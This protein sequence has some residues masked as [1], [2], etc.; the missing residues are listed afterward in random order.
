MKGAISSPMGVVVLNKSIVNMNYDVEV[1]LN[2][3]YQY[4][5]IRFKNTGM[6]QLILER[7]RYF[8]KTCLDTPDHKPK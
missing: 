2:R 6:I 1:H 4:A 3:F 8:L 7:L 5:L